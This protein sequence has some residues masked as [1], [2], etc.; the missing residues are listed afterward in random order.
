MYHEGNI[1]PQIPQCT[2]PNAKYTIQNRNV[3][4]S[5]LNGVLCAMGQVHCGIFSL[6]ILFTRSWSHSTVV[7]PSCRLSWMNKYISLGSSSRPSLWRSSGT[8]YGMT[9]RC[10]PCSPPQTLR[11]VTPLRAWWTASWGTRTSCNVRMAWLWNLRVVTMPTLSELV[12]LEVVVTTS[13]GTT[14]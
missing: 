1:L 3:H 6:F 2:S 5:V 7:A 4:I 9:L 11:S 8:S 12:V 10:S 14:V 13:T